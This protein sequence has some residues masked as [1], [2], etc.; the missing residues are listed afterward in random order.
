[1]KLSVKNL[2]GISWDVLY[3]HRAL[4]PQ[5][6]GVQGTGQALGWKEGTGQLET[7]YDGRLIMEH[8]YWL[9][10]NGCWLLAIGYWLMAFRCLPIGKP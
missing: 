2:I 8:G 3:L 6:M 9:M 5:I 1:M 10:S 7:N 4:R